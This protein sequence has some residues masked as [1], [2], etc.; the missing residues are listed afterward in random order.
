[1]NLSIIVAMAENGAIGLN[2]QLLWHLPDDLKFFKQHTLNK[3]I[4]MGR[5]TY[6][7]IGSKPLPKRTNVVISRNKHYSVAEG[8]LLFDSLSHALQHFQNEDEI[9]V[10]GGAQLY[11]LAWPLCNRLY[12]TLVHT[13][14]TADTFFKHEPDEHWTLVF[15]QHHEADDKHAFSFTFQIFDKKSR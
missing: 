11:N 10:I 9:F 7:S 14:P 12:R 5:K 2:N 13:I 3:P 8:V 15:E 4:I 1:M 6:E